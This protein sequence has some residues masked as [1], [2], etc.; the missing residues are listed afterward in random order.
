MDKQIAALATDENHMVMWDIDL[1]M[2]DLATVPSLPVATSKLIPQKW[3][4]IDKTY[5][6]TTDISKPIVLFELQDNKAYIADGNHRLYRAV[7]ENVPVMNVVFVPE[8]THLKYLFQCSVDDYYEVI[9]ELMTE[10]I[11]I[12]WPS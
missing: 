9:K 6:K 2:A 5:A 1:L 10:N 8:Q 12:D 3:L 4:T 7:T 11:F